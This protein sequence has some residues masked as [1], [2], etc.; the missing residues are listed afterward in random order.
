MAKN[1]IGELEK[2]CRKCGLK[3]PLSDFYVN[4]DWK[5]EFY[6]D[7]WC[8]KCVQ[9]F[10]V[11]EDTM[12]EYCRFNRRLWKDDVWEWCLT[13][14]K[15]ELERNE[16]YTKLKDMNKQN[17][18]YLNRVFKLF[19]QNM[20]RQQNYRFVHELTGYELEELEEKRKTDKNFNKGLELDY[21]E[22]QYSQEWLG[23]YSKG[24]LQYLD[25][26]F[27]G[28]QRD[29][30]LENSAYIDY[31][32]K[33]CKASLIMDRAFSDM[34]DGKSGAE[35]RYKD[36]KD[37]F[38]QLSQSA[39]FAEKTRSENDSV[40]LGSLGELVKKMET[41]GFLQKKIMFEKDDIDS[42]IDDYRWILTSVGEE[43]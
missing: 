14:T 34:L 38:D 1:K 33:V 3:L 30:K 37:I 36:F 16:E 10:V 13:R 29:F 40:G 32:K 9:S 20:N 19:Y 24:E 18:M 7:A 42:I 21:S 41:T 35:K 17:A 28:L 6:K 26:Y 11:S 4:L 5:S 2:K 8:K 25:K 15:D 39:K 12:K 27:E 23:F 43:F 31:A 22:K